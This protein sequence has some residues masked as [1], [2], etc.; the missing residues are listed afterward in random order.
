MT[1]SD[2][3]PGEGTPMPGVHAIVAV[4][5]WAVGKLIDYRTSAGL[6]TAIV[7]DLDTETM[8]VQFEIT[9]AEGPSGERYALAVVIDCDTLHGGH[10]KQVVPWSPIGAFAYVVQV[11]QA[12][13]GV[14]HA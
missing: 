5:Q 10:F 7:G 1:K 11:V 12:A 9:P 8:S 14:V 6:N 13:G 2:Q 4:R 3:K